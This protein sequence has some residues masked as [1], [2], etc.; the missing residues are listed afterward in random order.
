MKLSVSTH[1]ISITTINPEPP[2]PENDKNIGFLSNID[3]D[4]LKYY[5]CAKPAFSAW[6]SSARQGNVTLIF[7]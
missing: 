2:P 6:P 5:D 7:V 4:L 1:V 3:L